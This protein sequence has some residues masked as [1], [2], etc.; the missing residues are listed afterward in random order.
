MIQAM[1]LDQLTAFITVAECG[2]F[3]RAAMR[4]G[5]SQPLLSRKV[6]TLEEELGSD[7]FH[8]TG[9]GVVLSEAGKVF[10]QY[11]RGIVETAQEATRAV[12]ELGAAPVGHVCIGMP[13]SIAI[14]LA[15]ELVE[16]FRLA[17]PGVALK[18]M[19]GFSGHVMEWLAAGRLDVAVLYDAASLHGN[20]LRTDP[21]LCDELFL[22]GPPGDP[23]RLGH[24]P[25]PVKR[26]AEIP[27]VLPSRPHGVR[28]LVDE[29]MARAGAGEPHLQMEIDALHSSVA[30]VRGGQGYT[31]LSYAGVRDLVLDKRLRIWRLVEPTITRSLVIATG[32]QRPSTRPARALTRMF[33]EKL[34]A[35]MRE[36]VWTPPAELLGG[37]N[38][39]RAGQREA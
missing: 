6:K 21:L 13:S 26:L 7:L 34:E 8:R 37:G 23:A 27:M 15:V 28:L 30:L 3:S 32:T 4:L 22:V 35:K 9:R 12:R 33:K 20:T 31:V 17:Y 38:A 5:T 18:V 2:T 25:V 19:E 39:T 29:A 11:A 36:G 1:E 10:E 16:E 14:V 24:G